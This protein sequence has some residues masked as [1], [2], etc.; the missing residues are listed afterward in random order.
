MCACVCMHPRIHIKAHCKGLKLTLK[1]S[2]TVYR[3]EANLCETLKTIKAQTEINVRPAQGY[4]S[5]VFLFVF[6]SL[7]TGRSEQGLCLLLQL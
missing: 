1:A 7:V 2:P 4:I 3:K 6:A 5:V